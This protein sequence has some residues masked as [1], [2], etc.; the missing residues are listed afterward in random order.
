MYL[1]ARLIGANKRQVGTNANRRHSYSEALIN[2]MGEFAEH[3]K[4][5]LYYIIIEIT[6]I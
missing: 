6:C 3:S 4:I 1:Q 2:R 5:T